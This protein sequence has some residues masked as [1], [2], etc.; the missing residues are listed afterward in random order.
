MIYALAL[1]GAVTVIRW[2]RAQH[3]AYSGANH[4]IAWNM[5]PK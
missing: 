5:R 1:I 2:F 3:R 4:S